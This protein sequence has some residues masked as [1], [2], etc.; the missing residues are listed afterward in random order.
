MK[1]NPNN[2]YVDVGGSIDLFTKGVY[3]RFYTQEGDPFSKDA[4]IFRDLTL[5]NTIPLVIE[6]SLAESGCSK[7]YLV[8]LGVFFNPEYLELL[9]IFLATVKLFSSVDQ[10]D[11]LVLTSEDFQP[12]INELSHE[13]GIPLKTH[14]FSFNSVDEAS[15][16]RLHIFEYP[17]AT[18]Y[19]KI[20]Y[21][22]TDITAQGDL[23]N[24]FNEPL[25]EKVYG[26]KEGTI[27]HEIHGGW[28]FDFST[29]DKNTVAMNGGILLFRPTEVIQQI[30]SD[31]NAHV[32]RLKE[33]GE[34]MPK[35]AD[36]PF[37]NY[38]FIKSGRYNNTMLEKHGLIYCIDPPPPPSAPTD[39]VLCHFVWPIGNAGHK[40]GRMRPHVSHVLTHYHNIFGK[41][42]FH[43]KSM[44]E[45][46]YI[47]G[48]D[49]WI[50]FENNGLLITKWCN[51]TY[52][53]L[54]ANTIYAR[55]AGITHFL[56]FDSGYNN[57]LS[58]RIGDIDI[59]RGRMK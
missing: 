19:E 33:T 13:I 28:W 4:C 38:H 24:I 32:K 57:F 21:L 5:T 8:Y 41:K 11:F 25:E 44:E 30:F 7:K 39:V 1:A 35:C 53:W 34:R 54:D 10:I 51:G 18:K 22:D 37:V 46:K 14:Y 2:M 36:Q 59:V 23:M 31:I 27:E 43:V 48:L 40:L 52:E 55:W 56:R 15:C 12:R 29:I 26:M 49:G 16:A 42:E 45:S 50:R 6:D 47:W 58:V 9:K 3:S 17:D 20:M